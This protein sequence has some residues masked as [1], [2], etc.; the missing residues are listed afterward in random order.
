V[1]GARNHDLVLFARIAGFRRELCDDLLYPRHGERRLF[2]AYNKSLNLLPVSELP[3]HR[4]TWKRAE[5]RRVTLARSR[6]ATSTRAKASRPST[7]IGAS[8][9]H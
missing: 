9:R 3:W 7:D 6:R 8:P 4:F 2:E 1:T 5:G